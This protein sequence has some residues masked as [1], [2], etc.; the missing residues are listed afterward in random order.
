[1]YYEEITKGTRAIFQLSQYYGN[2]LMYGNTQK[3]QTQN[4]DIWD[5]RMLMNIIIMKNIL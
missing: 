2:S 5:Y 1:M 4:K 3:Y